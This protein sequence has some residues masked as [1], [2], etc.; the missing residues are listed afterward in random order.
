ME[1]DFATNDRQKERNDF[2]RGNERGL[3]VAS[4]NFG[5]LKLEEAEADSV[6]AFCILPPIFSIVEG[7]DSD[8]AA[9]LK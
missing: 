7:E 1:A 9:E 3:S 5:R 6:N 4:A 2:N 8:Y